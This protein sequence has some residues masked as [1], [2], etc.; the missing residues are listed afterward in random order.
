LLVVNKLPGQLVQG[1]KTGDLPL[2]EHLREYIRESENKP[3]NVFMGLTHR[4]DRPCS[5]IVVFAKTSKALER[6]NAIFRESVVKKTYWAVCESE[7]ANHSGTLKHF[8][9]KNE[10]QNKSYIVESETPH[11]K[12][13]ILNYQIMGKTERYSLIEVELITGRHHQIR[14]QLSHIGCP[15]K[16]DLKYGA[17]RS[18]KNGSIHLHAHGLAFVHPVKKECFRFVANPPDGDTLWNLFA[19]HG[20]LSSDERNIVVENKAGSAEIIGLD[21]ITGDCV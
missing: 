10:K 4:L 16:G 14:A 21:K 9:K 2:L 13:A 1:D 6:M 12:E 11:S 18:N 19:Q 7:P 15:I 5:G 20:V 3:G 17:S 8:L